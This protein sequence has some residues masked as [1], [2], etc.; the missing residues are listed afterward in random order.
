VKSTA[1]RERILRTPA[2]K[3]I[4]GKIEYHLKRTRKMKIS[5]P[6]GRQPEFV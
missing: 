3:N 2:N 1:P 6:L 4:R 5:Y